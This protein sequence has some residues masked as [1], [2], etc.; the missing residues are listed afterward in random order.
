M[1][2]PSLQPESLKKLVCKKKFS[3]T[4]TK[5]GPDK[6]CGPK[7][8][9]GAKEIKS[10]RSMCPGRPRP[11][12]AGRTRQRHRG[13]PHATAPRG[14]RARDRT[15]RAARTRQNR[16]CGRY[17][18]VPRGPQERDR[19]TAR[20]RRP[21]AHDRTPRAAYVTH[22]TAQRE[23][24]AR[25]RTARAAKGLCCNGCFGPRSGCSGPRSGPGPGSERG[26]PGQSNH[27]ACIMIPGQFKPVSE[28]RDGD[29]ILKAF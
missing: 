6:K 17:A 14:P 19:R 8:N 22:A 10:F 2:I 16:A 9:H 25:D 5:I 21:A 1:W 12:R 26:G 3:R 15:A 29:P 13:G 27:Y 7:E 11:Y 4:V 28:S 18:T 24:H 20:H 23:P